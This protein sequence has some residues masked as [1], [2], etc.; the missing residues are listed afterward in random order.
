MLIYVLSCLLLLSCLLEDGLMTD[1]NVLETYGS[2]VQHVYS[3]G[4]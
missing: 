2:H 1:R 4:Q 3:N